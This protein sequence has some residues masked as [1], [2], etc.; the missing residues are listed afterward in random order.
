[1]TEKKMERVAEKHQIYFINDFN[2]INSGNILIKLFEP[3]PRRVYSFLSI[4]RFTHLPSDCAIPQ[5]GH[6][7]LPVFSV[8]CEAPLLLTSGGEREGED[9][10]KTS[11]VFSWRAANFHP[12]DAKNE[13]KGAHARKSP[14]NNAFL[15]A[16]YTINSRSGFSVIGFWVSDQN[17]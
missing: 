6:I 16:F 7:Y 12:A 15:C 4:I 9:I 17:L 14:V 10:F 8:F 3:L 2:Q 13:S 5:S 11:R 1:M